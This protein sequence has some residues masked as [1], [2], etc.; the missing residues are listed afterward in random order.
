M[1]ASFPALA[2]KANTWA[3]EPAGPGSVEEGDY[4]YGTGQCQWEAIRSQHPGQKGPD[5]LWHHQL[6]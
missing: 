5:G 4:A 6:T 3:L 1:K 2:S